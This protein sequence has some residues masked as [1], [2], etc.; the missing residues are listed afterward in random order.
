VRP[1]AFAVAIALAALSGA[2]GSAKAHPY[3]PEDIGFWDASHGF[4][5]LSGFCAGTCSYAI[6]R[7]VD[8]GRTWTRSWRGR[9]PPNEAPA[10]TVPGGREAF[11]RG[12]ETDD[13]GVTWHRRRG[14]VVPAAFVTPRE[15]WGLR[16]YLRDLP[17]LVVTRDGGK[18]WK[19]L[20]RACPEGLA[21]GKWPA[22][23]TATHGWVLCESQPG[24]GN[25]VK[26][27]VETVDGGRTWRAR[28]LPRPWDGAGYGV[29]LSFRR[30]GRG[31]IAMERGPNLVTTDG[32]RT[33]RALSFP[34]WEEHG[35]VATL[36]GDSTVFAIAEGRLLSTHLRPHWVVVH[37]WP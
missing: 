24:A 32:G 1:V 31:L 7:T 29:R 5:L 17:Q 37:R 25:Q 33:W 13:G 36:A 27:L 19:R 28:P 11:V 20:P 3:S 21:D 2:A 12:L 22:L 23:V 16:G 26:A 14:R 9:L 15:G 30:D 34:G 10:V 18:T 35:V 8:G 6:D 4:V